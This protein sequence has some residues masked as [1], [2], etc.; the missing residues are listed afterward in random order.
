MDS[1]LCVCVCVCVC[2]RACVRVIGFTLRLCPDASI[3]LTK[4]II[5]LHISHQWWNP[6]EKLTVAQ[7]L[8]KFLPFATGVH[9]F[10]KLLEPSQNSQR[11]KQAPYWGTTHIRNYGTKFIRHGNL[12]PCV[13][14]PLL[15]RFRRLIWALINTCHHCLIGAKWIQFAAFS[16]VSVT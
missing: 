3:S 13:C 1:S 6:R 10:T 9:K 7:L 2:V 11:L 16:T 14:A 4:E 12:V 15:Y 5:V 8:L